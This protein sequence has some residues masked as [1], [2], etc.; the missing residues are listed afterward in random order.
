M[1]ELKVV[2]LDLAKALFQVHGINSQGRKLCAKEVSGS[3]LEL[4]H[5]IGARTA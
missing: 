2:G 4:Q 5:L 3:G 1:E